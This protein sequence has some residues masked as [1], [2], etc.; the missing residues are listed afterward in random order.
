M[1]MNDSQKRFAPVQYV[2]YG[3]KYWKNHEIDMNVNFKDEKSLHLI[4]IN[5]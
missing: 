5:F 2:C 3:I 4:L 1:I